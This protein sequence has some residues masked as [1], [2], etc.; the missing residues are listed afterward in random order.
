MEGHWPLLVDLLLRLLPV[1]HFRHLQ[2]AVQS[3]QEDL[4]EDLMADLLAWSVSRISGL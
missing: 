1:M 3:V 4:L 2:M